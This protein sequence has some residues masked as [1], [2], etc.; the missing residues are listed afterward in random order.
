MEGRMGPPQIQYG[1][2]ADGSYRK[3]IIGK[4]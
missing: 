3:C 2:G 1:S 4:E